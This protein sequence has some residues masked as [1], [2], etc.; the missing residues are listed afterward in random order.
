MHALKLY[1]RGVDLKKAAEIKEPQ[2]IMPA[3][4]MNE[5][6]FLVFGV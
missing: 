3:A 4:F 2:F 1:S 6:Y 5:F